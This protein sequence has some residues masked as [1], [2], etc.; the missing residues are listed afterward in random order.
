MNMNNKQPNT[1]CVTIHSRVF[2]HLWFHFN[3]YHYDSSL[4]I[5]ISVSKYFDCSKSILINIIAIYCS[6]FFS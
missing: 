2:L 3:D 6:T 1:A 4:I 5:N